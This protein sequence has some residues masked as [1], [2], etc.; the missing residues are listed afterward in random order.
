[1]HPHTET[2]NYL[3]KIKGYISYLE[4]GVHIP[5]HNFDLVKCRYKIGVDPNGL[6]TFTGTSDEFFALPHGQKFDII[7]IDG[8]HHK[9][10]VIKDFSNSLLCLNEGGLI[11]I[12]DTN[13]AD[14]RYTLVPREGTRGRWNGDCYKFISCLKDFDYKTVDYD[15]NGL[16]VVKP[17]AQPCEMGNVSY[18]WFTVNKKKYLNLCTRQEF[19]EWI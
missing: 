17:G 10:Q 12:H 13:P 3:I 14:Y 18:D 15:A 6:A 7:F 11:L 16:T 4:I 8:L 1:M 2:I 19:E 9:E 5:A